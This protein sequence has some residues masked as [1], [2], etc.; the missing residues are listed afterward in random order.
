MIYTNYPALTKAEENSP[1]SRYYH[2]PMRGLDPLNNQI[3]KSGP[4][5]P[6]K[7]IP[8]QSFTDLLKKDDYFDVELG[9]CRMPDGSAYVSTYM[10]YPK[11]TMEMLSWWFQWLNE[12]CAAAAP[13]TNL[14][15]RVWNPVDH[16]YHGFVNGKD[17]TD[18][19]LMVE[20]LDLGQG[21]TPLYSVSKKLDRKACGISD[22]LDNHLKAEG[23]TYNIAL[24]TFFSYEE[25]HAK[26]P[27]TH[28]TLSMM[29]PLPGGG[30]EA[31]G[32]EWIGYTFIDGKVCQDKD[33]PESMM[34]DEFL[35]KVLTHCTIEMQRLGDILPDMYSEFHK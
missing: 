33:T 1:L 4:M 2:L 30:V 29:R 5:D 16:H 11:C 27:G 17:D 34:T 20:S 12:P 13:G 3:I 24:E 21:D 23:C 9:A 25:P 22:E 26:L 32:R 6:S 10:T 31:R 15:Y 8:A 19:V 14:K 28:L 7:A 18:G 35:T